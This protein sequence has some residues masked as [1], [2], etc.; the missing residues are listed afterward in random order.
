MRERILFCEKKP[1]TT[2]PDSAGKSSASMN[3]TFEPTAFGSSH[4]VPLKGICAAFRLS[5]EKYTRKDSV[6]RDAMRAHSQPALLGNT[7][8]AVAAERRSM[9]HFGPLPAMARCLL[10]RAHVEKY[11]LGHLGVDTSMIL[12]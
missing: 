7:G 1:T 9:S 6:L 3:G 5:D 2:C 8:D 11:L 12:I 4:P 10:R